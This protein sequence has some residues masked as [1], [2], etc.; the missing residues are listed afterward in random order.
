MEV[1]KPVL[2]KFG[3]ENTG[4][5][6]HFVFEWRTRLACAQCTDDQVDRILGSCESSYRQVLTIPKNEETCQIFPLESRKAD[7]TP[8]YSYGM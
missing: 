5:K 8:V 6:C 1:G 4:E 3:V 7:G 2:K